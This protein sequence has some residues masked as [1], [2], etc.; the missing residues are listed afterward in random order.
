MDCVREEQTPRTTIV[1]TSADTDE[2]GRPYGASDGDK[3]D[4]AIV[5]VTLE[6][7][8]IAG[9]DTFLNIFGVTGRTALFFIFA[10]G[11]HFG[12][13]GCFGCVG[14]DSLGFGRA[15]WEIRI[16]DINQTRYEADRA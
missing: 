6:V 15:R 14:W 10:W 2:E 11:R 16:R 9:H 12:A 1:E 13:F 8:G 5:Q 3:L 7:V 4:L